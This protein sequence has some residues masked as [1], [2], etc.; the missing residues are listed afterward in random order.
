MGV[1]CC[2]PRMGGWVKGKYEPIGGA[3]AKQKRKPEVRKKKAERRG[4]I[5][6]QTL[7]SA[8]LKK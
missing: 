7:L 3:F 8:P 1:P 5:S 6:S 4:G 2:C